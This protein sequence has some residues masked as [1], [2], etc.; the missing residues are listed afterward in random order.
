MS[1]INK[2]IPLMKPTF[3]DDNDPNNPKKKTFIE[4]EALLKEFDEIEPN[5]CYDD[6]HDM[7][8]DCRLSAI[9]APTADVV[10]VRH[11]YWIEYSNDPNIITCSEC[12][13]GEGKAN[14]NYKICPM[15]G[16]KMDGE[17]NS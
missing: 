1:D 17:K 7:W 6:E 2:G 3:F 4:R 13:W 16:A 5:E 11:G 8:L 15:C 10:E 9:Q 14:K 12:D